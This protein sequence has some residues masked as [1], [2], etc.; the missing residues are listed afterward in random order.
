MINKTNK[1]T[2]LSGIAFSSLLA[3]CATSSMQP[4]PVTP[5]LVSVPAGNV[6]ALSAVGIGELTYECHVKATAPGEF[7]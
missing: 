3:A 5:A 4:M 1:A 6:L 7:K 2:L